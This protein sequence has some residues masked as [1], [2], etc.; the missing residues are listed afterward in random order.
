LEQQMESE[1]CR[2]EV[3]ADLLSLPRKKRLVLL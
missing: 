3:V 2:N 1:N